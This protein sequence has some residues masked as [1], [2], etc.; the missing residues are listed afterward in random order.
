[1]H[2]YYIG[3]G[4][5]AAKAIIMIL[6]LYACKVNIRNYK[7][8]ILYKLIYFYA[9]R[10]STYCTWKWYAVPPYKWSVSLWQDVYIKQDTAGQLRSMLHWVELSWDY[11]GRLQ[12]TLLSFLSGTDR[13]ALHI[14]TWLAQHSTDIQCY[15]TWATL[16]LDQ[17]KQDKPSTN[18]QTG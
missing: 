6:W 13:P 10:Y 11:S 16:S 2:D 1:M 3:T 15:Y 7:Y 8:R 12:F 9:A 14:N 5:C 4:K 18:V 17:V